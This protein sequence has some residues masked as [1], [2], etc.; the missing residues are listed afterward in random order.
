LLISLGIIC[1]SIGLKEFLLPNNFLDGGA[2]GL[3]LLANVT[4]NVELSLLIVLI[5]LPFILIGAKQISIPFAIKSTL[6]IVA[7]SIII[8]FLTL[9]TITED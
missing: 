7:L 6:A 3:S 1:A 5:N 4:T 8:H 9:P 2:M